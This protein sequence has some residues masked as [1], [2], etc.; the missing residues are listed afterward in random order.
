MSLY[1]LNFKVTRKSEKSTFSGFACWF[2]FNFYWFSYSSLQSELIFCLTFFVQT[3]FLLKFVQL[4]YS[5]EENSTHEDLD[6]RLPDQSGRQS[7]FVR[8]N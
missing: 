8:S 3:Y 1:F 2:N 5:G 7:K 6:L 4:I